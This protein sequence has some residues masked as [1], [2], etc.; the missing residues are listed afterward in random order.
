MM[1]TVFRVSHTSN[2]KLLEIGRQINEIQPNTFDGLDKVVNR[3]SCV[4]SEKDDW[5]EHIADIEFFIQIFATFLQSLDDVEMCIDIAISLQDGNSQ[6]VTISFNQDF[7]RL[8][9][10]SKIALDLTFYET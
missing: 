9:V 4:V 6:F 1:I 5:F 3:F 10:E 8:L 7:M 2:E